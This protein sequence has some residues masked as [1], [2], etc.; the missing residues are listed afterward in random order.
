VTA[1]PRSRSLVSLLA[2]LAA[3]AIV[4]SSTVV[5]SATTSAGPV[6]R[7]RANAHSIE[8]RVGAEHRVV[9][10][11]VGRDTFVYDQF[12]SATGVATETGLGASNAATGPALARQLAGEEASSIF[13]SS[14]GLQRS[15]LDASTPLIRGPNLGNQQLV[16][17]LTADGSNLADWA[18]YTTPAFNSPSGPFQVHFYMNSSTGAVHY[19]D[20]FKV[21]FNG[22]R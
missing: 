9:A 12:V 3:V 17:T 14:G 1:R 11:R 5:A 16:K 18:K 4:A 15:V 20:D 22:P 8:T 13:T 10:G 6:T 19:L 21:V 7:V 2:L